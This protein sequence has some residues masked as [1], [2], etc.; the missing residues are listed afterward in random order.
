MIIEFQSEVVKKEFR[1]KMHVYRIN[2]LCLM[3]LNDSKLSKVSNWNQI[4]LTKT[5]K[6]GIFKKLSKWSKLKISSK[7]HF[8]VRYDFLSVKTR[9][10]IKFWPR[11]RGLKIQKIIR[12]FSSFCSFLYTIVHQFESKMSN[13]KNYQQNKQFSSILRSTDIFNFLKL[14]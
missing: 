3:D 1:Y 2:F 12:K 6:N 14:S 10:K 8:L 5:R 4:L 7:W 13:T 9:F 11:N